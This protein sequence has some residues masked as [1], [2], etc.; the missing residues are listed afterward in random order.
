MSHVKVHEAPVASVATVALYRT[1]FTLLVSERTFFFPSPC[2]VLYAVSMFS[3]SFMEFDIFSGSKN[4]AGSSLG[5][6]R[7]LWGIE[8]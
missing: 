1:A 2:C 5:F 8:E 6:L 3:P 4:P 7:E